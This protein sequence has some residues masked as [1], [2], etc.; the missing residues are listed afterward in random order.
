MAET[1]FQRLQAMMAMTNP[2]MP[3]VPETG[4]GLWGSAAL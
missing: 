1:R 2:T 3:P 4:A